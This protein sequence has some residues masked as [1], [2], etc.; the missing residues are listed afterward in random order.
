MSALGQKRSSALLSG[1]GEKRTRH[2]AACGEASHH[3]LVIDRARTDEYIE[4]RWSSELRI[5]EVQR[6]PS[7]NT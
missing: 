4:I 3:P 5:H 7:V 6:L 2:R 1:F